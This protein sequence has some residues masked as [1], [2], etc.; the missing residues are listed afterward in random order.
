MITIS[1]NKELFKGGELQEPLLIQTLLLERLGYV[2]S[3]SN[4]D[5]VLKGKNPI[6]VTD[7]QLYANIPGMA[8]EGG[9]YGFEV[10][11]SKLS[12]PV[13]ETWPASQI[14]ESEVLHH[15]ETTDEEGFVV[16][17][18]NETILLTDEGEPIMRQ[19]TFDE[20]CQ[21]IAGVSGKVYIMVGMAD[22]NGNIF[23]YS[24]SIH[25]MF[26]AYF[27]IENLIERNDFNTPE[28]NI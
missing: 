17:A 19:K 27:G 11:E 22:L 1:I 21:T 20:Y 26:W 24:D 5:V 23:D 3:F 7:L 10:N 18:W 12:E 25:R 14:Q 2:Q 9:A 8:I 28:D 4:S 6:K 15:E 16:P 13:P